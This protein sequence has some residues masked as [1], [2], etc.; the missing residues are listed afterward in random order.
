MSG[1]TV[2]Q[3]RMLGEM[4]AGAQLLSPCVPVRPSTE[5][6]PSTFT[7]GHLS[8]KP[9]WK[10]PYRHSRRCVFK[11]V[12]NLLKLTMIVITLGNSVVHASH[13]SVREADP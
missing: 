8:L 4:N 1:H 12:V 10:Q 2:S 6:S 5:H 3:V 13:P 7:V 11:P 9:P